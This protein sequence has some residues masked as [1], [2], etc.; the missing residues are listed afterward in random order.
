MR[1]RRRHGLTSARI[2]IFSFLAVV[3]LGG[4]LLSL[5]VSSASGQWTP[6]FDA[7]FTAISATCVTGLVV[8]DTATY[9]SGFGQGV[10]LALIQ[11]GGLGVITTAFIVRVFS[12]S[13]V[14]LIQRSLLKDSISGDNVAGIIR[15]SLFILKVVVVV[16]LSGAVL[17][18]PVFAR[19]FGP[20][21]GVWYALFHSVSAFCNAGFDLMGVRGQFSSLTAYSGDVVVNLVI[22]A[23]IV[24]GGIGFYT[25]RDFAEHGLRLSRF[26]LQSKVS[27]AAA[28]ALIVVPALVLAFGA[29]AGLPPKERVL[30]SL[31]QSVT[32]R[33]AG[34]NTCDLTQ[35]S[36]DDVMMMV[37]LMLVG[38]CS[39]STAGGMKTTTFAI[40]A[41]TLVAIA[42]R[43]DDT[44]LFQRRIPQATVRSAAALLVLYLL[45]SLAGA[46]VI[47]ALEGLPLL[48]CLFE[49]ASAMGT[50]GLT[51]GVTPG[52][53]AASHAILMALMFVGRV[54]GLTFLFAAA[55]RARFD[56]GHFPKED[57]NVG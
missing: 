17:L 18:Y 5:P 7:L 6:Y 12:G 3:L 36:Q 37:L 33:T 11:V 22:M 32:T 45:G 31:F 29:Y 34:F 51:L 23:L 14:S 35:L 53:H 21:L 24:V 46:A 55:P 8:R 13:K 25:W 28:A 48:T 56:S 52:L 1:S 44:V 42:R 15:M 9:W 40:L 50:V 4:L 47:S 26:R 2:I 39:G 49:T 10:I 20:M 43:S 30:A 41:A 57:V 38:G 16:E 27:L 54:G 19:D